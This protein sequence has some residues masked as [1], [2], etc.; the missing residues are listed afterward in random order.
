LA[1]T[2]NNAKQA[3]DETSASASYGAMLNA[4]SH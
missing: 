4:I 1:L 3:I 2:V